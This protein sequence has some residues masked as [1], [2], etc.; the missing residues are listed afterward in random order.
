MAERK[1]FLLRID[2]TVLE[3][4]QRWANDDLRSLNAQIEYLLREALRVGRSRGRVAVTAARIASEIEARPSLRAI[5]TRRSRSSLHPILE[6]VADARTLTS[7]VRPLLKWAG[8]KRQLLPAL[9]EHYPPTFTRYIEPFVGSGAVFFDLLNA[10]RLAP[11]DQLA[12]VNADLIGC[13]RT[14]RDRPEEVIRALTALAREHRAGG[15]ACYYEV[16]D[17]RFNPRRV[18]RSRR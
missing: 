11:G 4:V 17:D 16:R 10:G 14:L 12:D 7:P 15:D 5:G 9:A 18:R 3:G 6:R 2:A 8:G 13:Y 1:P